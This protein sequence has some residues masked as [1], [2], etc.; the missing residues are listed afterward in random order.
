EL[1]FLECWHVDDGDFTE[2]I[3]MSRNMGFMRGRGLPGRGWDMGEPLWIL[4]VVKD[5]NFPRAKAAEKSGLHGAFAFPVRLKDHVLGVMEFFSRKVQEPDDAL[6]AMMDAVGSQIGQFIERKNAEAKAKT[7]LQEVEK[8][9]HQVEEQ[10]REITDSINYAQRIQKALLAS[11]EMLNANFKENFVFFQPKDVVSG[12]FYWAAE[13]DNK[14][15]ALVTADSTGH[16]VPGAIMSMLN[17]SCL[18]D[19]VEGK[20]LTEPNEILNHTRNK[21]ITHLKND[22]SAEGGKDGMDCSLIS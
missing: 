14:Q 13:L 12:D 3:D 8:Q 11:D 15:V 7:Y 9:K 5:T 17:I 21:I 10:H 22:G 20:K 6:L 1:Q 18:N 16:G 4:D 2:F 19:A